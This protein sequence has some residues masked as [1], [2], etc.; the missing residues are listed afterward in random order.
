MPKFEW[1]VIKAKPKEETLLNTAQAMVNVNRCGVKNATPWKLSK[2]KNGTDT[3][4]DKVTEKTPKLAADY[5]DNRIY[6]TLSTIEEL[7]EAHSF[8]SRQLYT[9]LVH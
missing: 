4:T 3:L 1:N 7:P 5:Q 6:E 2:D 9:G 8:S